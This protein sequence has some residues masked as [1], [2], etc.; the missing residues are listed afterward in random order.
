MIILI[1]VITWTHAVVV[2]SSAGGEVAQ[3]LRGGRR[4]VH[5][6]RPQT[7]HRQ[8]GT[9]IFFKKNIFCFKTLLNISTSILLRKHHLI[10]STIHSL[11]MIQGVKIQ[12]SVPNFKFWKV[13]WQST[14]I[15]LK[16][17][18]EE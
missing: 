1:I 14:I 12:F 3:L 16:I 2:E 15:V 7:R 17:F 11:K 8:L 9:N 18:I 6:R 10:Y 13:H 4:V 5:H